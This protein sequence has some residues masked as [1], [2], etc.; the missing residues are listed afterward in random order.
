MGKNS[1]Y[2]LRVLHTELVKGNMRSSGE[3][4]LH[5]PI[6]PLQHCEIQLL[7]TI[8]IQLWQGLTRLLLLCCH[9]SAFPENKSSNFSP[10]PLNIQKPKKKKNTPTTSLTHSLTHSHKSPTSLS[11]PCLSFLSLPLST[12][13]ANRTNWVVHPQT[14]KPFQIAMQKLHYPTIY[15]STQKRVEEEQQQQEAHIALRECKGT[16]EKMEWMNE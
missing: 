16:N 11:F 9:S 3:N 14:P 8:L 6:H 5:M 4:I 1:S 13:R 2:P 7:G 12:K 10:T 15:S